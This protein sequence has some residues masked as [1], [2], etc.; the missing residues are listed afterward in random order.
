MT[1]VGRVTQVWRYPVKS[2]GGEQLTH[3]TL[4]AR[5]ILGDRGW[6]LRDEQAG[7][8][9]GAKKL[10]ELLQCGARYLG[11]PTNDSIPSAEISLPDGSSMRSDDV[12]AG[13]R[14]RRSR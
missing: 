1:I 9:R 12:G 10:P 14:I 6:A 4:G 13:A 8:I 5:G 2:M 7:E 3:G 11:E